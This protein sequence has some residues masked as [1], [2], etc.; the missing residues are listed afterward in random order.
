MIPASKSLQTGDQLPQLRHCTDILESAIFSDWS[1][2]HHRIH[3]DHE[4]ARTEGL[5]HA[6]VNSGV[7]VAWVEEDI[8]TIFGNVAGLKKLDF[9]FQHPVP[10]GATVCFGG[11]VK[12]TSHEGGVLTINIGIW[13]RGL[14][15]SV[16]L[17]G[18][19]S[20]ELAQ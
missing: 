12:S 3:W 6:I 1:G 7:L 18:N 13:V 15:D 19:A 16:H 4:Y 10:I 11:E 8:Q 20:I 14:E 2:N 9:R 17:T 5:S